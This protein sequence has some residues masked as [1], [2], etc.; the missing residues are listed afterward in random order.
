MPHLLQACAVTFEVLVCAFPLLTFFFFVF[1]LCSLHIHSPL[2]PA[3]YLLLW[4]GG[5]S[6][7]KKQKTFLKKKRERQKRERQK[8]E[9]Q[10]RER[11]KREPKRYCYF[12][13]Y[14]RPVYATCRVVR[15]GKDSTKY[16]IFIFI[17]FY[18]LFYLSPSA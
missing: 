9:R 7:A 3:N 18:F 14:H 8:R 2:F 16:F 12:D 5:G 10:K 1:S 11:Q 17:F 13:C 15:Q 6:P 4:Y